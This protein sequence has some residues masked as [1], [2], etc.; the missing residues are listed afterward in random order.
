MTRTPLD[1]SP[2]RWL[3]LAAGL[4]MGLYA[5]RIRQPHTTSDFTIFYVSAQRPAADMYKRPVGPPRGNMNAPHFQLLLRPLTRLSLDAAAEVWRGLNILAL[6]GCVWWLARRSDEKW[7]AADFGAALAWAPFHHTLTLNQVTWIMWPLLVCAWWCWRKERW[8]AGAVA[9]GVALS[10][11]AFLGVFLIWLAVRRQWRAFA[12]AAATAAAAIGVGVAAY[13]IDVGRAWVS[14]MTGAEWPS[15]FSNA[16]L[17]GLFARNLTTNQTGAPPLAVMPQL[18]MPL[19]LIAAVIV[20]AVTIVR[21]R[22]RT[23][24]ES[25]P[26][27]MASA[28]LASPLGWTYYLWWILPGTRPS[29]VLFQS[30]I[31]W[32]P[33]IYMTYGQPSPWATLTT[34]SMYCWGL[35][36]AWVQFVGY[37][38]ARVGPIEA[39]EIVQR[40]A[41]APAIR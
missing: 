36:L 13:G 1:A 31:L 26:A 20:V 38:V 27:L 8:T 9:F 3:L 23:V 33:M 11:K 29:R 35:L 16:S 41:H 14:A 10:F 17:R 28:L 6:C 30:P 19:F 32:I 21:T 24:D 25:W 40:D 18:A 39:R 4:T 34:G 7:G 2:I 22:A 37:G 15:A 12:V 5:W